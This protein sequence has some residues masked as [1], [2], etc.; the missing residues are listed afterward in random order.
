MSRL[1]Q[2]SPLLFARFRLQMLLGRL[3]LSCSRV[4][5]TGSVCA[6]GMPVI[7]IYPGSECRIGEGC[8]LISVSF[9]T[10]LG[11]NH[12][13]VLRTLSRKAEIEIGS[14]VGISGGSICAARSIVIGD[15]TM[16]GANVTITDTDFHSLSPQMREMWVLAIRSKL[17]KT[18]LSEPMQSF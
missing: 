5:L 2:F 17:A 14:H 11:V 4:E 10:A 9:A 15:W 1:R 13:V 6:Y 18:Y 8:M 12:P 7:S 16:I 3:R